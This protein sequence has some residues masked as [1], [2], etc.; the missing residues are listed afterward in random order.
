MLNEPV[1]ILSSSILFYPSSIT[2][3]GTVQKII[4]LP[5][6]PTSME[7]LTLEEV[8]VFRVCLVFVLFTALEKRQKV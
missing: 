6:D 5:K 3:R 1:S 8:E 2:D 7:E 4:V